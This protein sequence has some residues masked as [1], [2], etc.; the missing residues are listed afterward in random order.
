MAVLNRHRPSRC[1]GCLKRNRLCVVAQPGPIC[2]KCHREWKQVQVWA[3][4][5]HEMR[6]TEQ[7]PAAVRYGRGCG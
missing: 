2:P 5:A 6:P 4:E 3:R 7:E 1:V